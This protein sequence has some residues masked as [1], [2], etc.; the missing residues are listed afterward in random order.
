MVGIPGPGLDEVARELVRDL[1]VGGIILFARNLK[2]PEQV[3]QLTHDLQQEARGAGSPPLLI[4][5]DQ[6][7]GPV[8][9]LKAPFTLIPPARELGLTRTPE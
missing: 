1:K 3:W 6:E 4:A 7:G 2:S 5:V 9:R 8:Q